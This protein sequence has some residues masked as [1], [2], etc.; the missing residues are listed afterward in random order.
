MNAVYF[1]IL[2]C[3]STIVLYYNRHYYFY[4]II[5]LFIKS[6]IIIWKDDNLNKSPLNEISTITV[7]NAIKF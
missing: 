7:Q 2:Y 1:Q 3:S 4:Y 6:Y 5:L